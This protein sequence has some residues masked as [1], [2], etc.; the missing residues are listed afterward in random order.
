MP[1]RRGRKAKKSVLTNL[2]LGFLQSPFFA[3]TGL[4]HRTTADAWASNGFV[5]IAREKR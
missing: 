2:I 3:P 5:R 4:T 1:K